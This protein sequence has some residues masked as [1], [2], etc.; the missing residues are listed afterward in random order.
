[1]DHLRTLDSQ[2]PQSTVSLPTISWEVH[3]PLIWQE[4]VRELARHP[5][6][7]F[8]QYIL[9]GI[10]NGFRIGFNRSCVLRLAGSNLCCDNPCNV[11]EYL[12]REVSLNRM[13]RLPRGAKS[14]G[15]HLS[16][17]GLIPKKNKPGK[18]RLIVDLSSPEETS[19]NDGIS[20][21]PYSTPP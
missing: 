6:Q 2:R 12:Y 7:M 16:P 20:S 15:I 21:A 3:T 4:W 18:W 17:L 13:W 11:R 8:S 14:R 10:L 5:D 19:V 1:M 9:A